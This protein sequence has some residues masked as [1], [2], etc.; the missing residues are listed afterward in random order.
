MRPTI[1]CHERWERIERV[2]DRL[3]GN[4]TLRELERS[5]AIRPWEIEQS[6][7][8]GWLTITTR[9]SRVG[10]PSRV[11][12]FRDYNIAETPALPNYRFAIEKSISPKHLEFAWRCVHEATLGGLRCLGIP[13]IVSA[14]VNTYHPRSKG[15]AYSSASRLYRHPD[16]RAARHWF[17]GEANVEWHPHEKMPQSARGIWMRL[18]EFGNWRANLWLM[19]ARAK[20]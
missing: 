2:L 8:L 3:G 12:A 18:R 16:V 19:Q 10:R 7:E 6:A 4:A 13:G 1:L 5:Y 20:T 14:Y 17:H 9:R 11:V 15:G